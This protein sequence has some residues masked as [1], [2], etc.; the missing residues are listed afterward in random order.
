M[1]LEKEVMEKLKSAMR[2]KDHKQ[3]EALRAIKAALL[4]AKTAAG[5]SDFTEEDELKLLQRLVKQRLDS[6]QIYQEQKREDLAK[7]EEEQATIIAQFLP[8]QLTEEEIEAKIDEIITSTGAASMKDMGKVMGAASEAMAGKANNKT[9]SV[10]V[11]RK[12]NA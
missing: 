9:I 1:S 2:N 11:R 6:M 12:L 4:N 8:K 5:A 10:I 7:A 3:M